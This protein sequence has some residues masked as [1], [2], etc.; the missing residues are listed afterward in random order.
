[1][2]NINIK[3]LPDGGNP[4]NP[5]DIWLIDGVW[6]IRP[7]SEDDDGNY[8][9]RMDVVVENDSQSDICV[10]FK[11]LWG[12][13]EHIEN[14]KHYFLGSGDDWKRF[15]AVV[16]GT[17][18]ILDTVIP[19]GSSYLCLHP[20]YNLERF[21]GFLHSLPTSIY[22]I[23]K[24]AK[25]RENRDIFAIEAGDKDLKPIVVLSRV[26]PYETIG[27]FMLE[28]MVNCLSKNRSAYLSGHRFIFIP[29]PNPDGVFNGLCKRTKGGLNFEAGFSPET[30]EPEGTGI[31]N[32]LLKEKPELIIDLHGW[33][34]EHDIFLTNDKGKI[35]D[36]HMSLVERKDLFPKGMGIMYGEYPIFGGRKN[37]DAIIAHL[38]EGIYLDTSFG[39]YERDTGKVKYLG[40][41]ILE[42]LM[43]QL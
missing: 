8:K 14:R 7:F 23:I 25:S 10:K 34:H 11:I 9:F 43:Q 31:M 36:L 35:R 29:M 6:H 1:M 24:I 3:V 20:V 37:F 2:E 19:P 28:G 21:N 32:Y 27:S 42:K 4:Q 30:A 26:H 40:S 38:S 16:E 12:D 17:T 18:C 22:R 15:D 33:M 13:S 5:G 39:W 41:I